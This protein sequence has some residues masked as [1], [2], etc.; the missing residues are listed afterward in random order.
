MT[1]FEDS[2]TGDRAFVV[3]RKMDAAVDLAISIEG[4]GDIEVFMSRDVALEIARS[5]QHAASG[6]GCASRR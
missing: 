4:D 1:E 5:L 6:P 2:E 3:V